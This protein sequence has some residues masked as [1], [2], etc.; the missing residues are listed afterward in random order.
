MTSFWK[1]LRSREA[2]GLSALLLLFTIL[3]LPTFSEPYW[4]G[5]EGIYL[6][7]GTALNHG[8]KLYVDIVDHKTP[9]IYWLAQ[10]GGQL[11]FRILLYF[12]MLLTTAAL[13]SIGKQLSLSFW[14]RIGVGALF[15]LS[16]SLPAFEGNIPNG[17]LFVIGFVVFSLWLLFRSQLIQAW[18]R[19]ESPRFKQA[20]TIWLTAAG[21]SL[22]LA[23]LTK[24]P[25]LFDLMGVCALI[26]FLGLNRVAPKLFTH[27]QSS[28]RALV[29]FQLAITI[30]VGAALA[31]IAMSAVYFALLGSLE[32]YLQFGLLYNF[33]YAGNWVLD[34]PSALEW[35]FTL[36]GKATAMVLV[37]TGLMF[38]PRSISPVFRWLMA[39]STFALFASLLS[40]RPYPHYFL[41]LFLPLSLLIGL[42]LPRCLDMR[43]RLQD[44]SIMAL[45][46]LALILLSIQ[47]MLLIQ[48]RPYPTISYYQNWLL[49]A[50]GNASHQDYVYAFNHLVENNDRVA[51]TYNFTPGEVMYIWGTNP[52]LY[53]LTKTVPADRFT[54]A[55]HVHDLRVYAETLESVRVAAPRVIIV[56][57]DETDT[58]PGLQQLLEES[59]NLDQ[60]LDH[61]AVWVQK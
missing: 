49:F 16:T 39:W 55:F 26:F 7:I 3:K 61:F 24:V 54:V 29:P 58:L 37:T 52:M 46:T 4:Y 35:W 5:D 59:Y 19:N 25:G 48:L 23:M 38:L 53:A 12:W 6:T 17:E 60:D 41:Q 18:L 13:F 33:H 9:V 31:T 14:T 21:I 57:H 15:V 44:R 56:M 50:S 11:E 40:N 8:S 1:Y 30:I 10:V 32:A 28:V 43:A 51:Q 27:F 2:L 42:T 20:D 47:V 22:G 45:S 34:V 36:P